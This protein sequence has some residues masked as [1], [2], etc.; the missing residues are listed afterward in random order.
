MSSSDCLPYTVLRSQL[1]PWGDMFPSIS[2]FSLIPRVPTTTIAAGFVIK[3]LD[4]LS[5]GRNAK[6]EALPL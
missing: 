3:V 6:G 1:Q 5:V 4:G 2:P